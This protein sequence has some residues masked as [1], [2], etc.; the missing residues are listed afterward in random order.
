MRSR[1]RVAVVVPVLAA[2]VLGACSDASDADDPATDDAATDETAADESA[3]D[4]DAATASDDPATDPS[5][6]PTA[7]L[8]DAP[9]GD[10]AATVAGTEIP[11]ETVEERVGLLGEAA[12]VDTRST[13]RNVLSQL[14]QVTAVRRAAA[15]E[16]GVDLEDAVSGP[17][18]SAAVA[19]RIEAG[20]GEQAF[21]DSAAAQGIPPDSAVA[22]A[23][24]DAEVQLLVEAVQDALLEQL[25]ED[26]VDEDELRAQYESDPSAYQSSDVAH[27]LLETEQAA[28]DALDRLEA[29][30]DFDELARELSTGPSGPNGGELGVNPRGTFVEE[31]QEAVYAES[32]EP[33]EVVGPVETEFGF[34]LIRVNEIITQ[35]FDEVLRQAQLEAIDDDFTAFIDTTF[36][37]AEVT[38]DPYYGSWDPEQTTIVVE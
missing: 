21:E 10:V 29:G 33:G 3:G 16:L 28:Q 14:V 22:L 12:G 18:I 20:G 23:E 2:L 11:V 32:T 25:P 34:H 36:S 1:T 8:P 27:I 19:E 13:E 9:E 30:E 37:E 6:D 15:D 38:V 35:P 4:G 26:A 5:T 24:A 17:A 7:D 31:F